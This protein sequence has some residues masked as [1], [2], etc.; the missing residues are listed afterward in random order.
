MSADIENLTLGEFAA[1]YKTPSEMWKNCN[2]PDWMLW[3][4]YEHNYRNAEKLERYIDWLRDQVKYVSEELLRGYFSYEGCV[5]QFD[6]DVNARNANQSKARRRRFMCTWHTAFDSVGY[7]LQD[8]VERAEF[9][10]HAEPIINAEVGINLP[11]TDFDEIELR[12][13]VLREQADK[14]R[15]IIGNPFELAGVNDFSS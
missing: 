8:K 6:K 7:V 11:A 14:L 10:H 4:L 1:K 3:I 5:K 2:R 12:L 9:N 13:A 15:E